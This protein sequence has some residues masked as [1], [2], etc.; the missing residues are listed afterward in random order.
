MN[1]LNP[2]DKFLI[3]PTGLEVIGKPTFDEWMAFGQVLW[4]IKSAVQW[5]LADWITYGE[6]KFG[7]KYAQAIDETKQ[8]YQTLANY[9]WVGKRFETS[10][11]RGNLS[12][13]HHEAVAAIPDPVI[14]DQ[15]LTEAATRKLNRDEIRKLAKPHKPA[16]PPKITLNFTPDPVEPPAPPEK[17]LDGLGYVRDIRGQRV[18][19]EVDSAILPALYEAW[20]RK[21]PVRMVVTR[22]EDTPDINPLVAALGSGYSRKIDTRLVKREEISA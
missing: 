5:A 1:N 8:S 11:R 7:D 10:R 19:I 21:Q 14:R 18:L 3:T 15:L 16:P 4:G 17:L 6:Q 9:V 13:S 12:F 20:Q 22:T 2:S